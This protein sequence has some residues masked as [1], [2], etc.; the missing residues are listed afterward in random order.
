MI[1]NAKVS[2]R[3]FGTPTER[4]QEWTSKFSPI[5][6]VRPLTV[7]IGIGSIRA[8]RRQRRARLKTR[9]RTVDLVTR[10]AVWASGC[11]SGPGKSS[12]GFGPLGSVYTHGTCR[13]PGVYHTKDGSGLWG[14]NDRFAGRTLGTGAVIDT[15]DP[16]KTTVARPL[17]R[18]LP[19]RAPR[20]RSSYVAA[21]VRPARDPSERGWYRGR[22]WYIRYVAWRESETNLRKAILGGRRACGGHEGGAR[23]ESENARGGHTVS[24]IKGRRRRRRRRLALSI[25][26]P[27]ASVATAGEGGSFEIRRPPAGLVCA[28]ETRDRGK[29]R[30]DDIDRKKT[31]ETERYV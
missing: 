19:L 20:A 24:K 30:N 1:L 15:P 27:R 18:P 29:E 8:F 4:S 21:D 17:P 9:L 26:F 10:I 7:T 31:T 3:T 14:N 16:N 28:R 6:K 2:L 22:C 23:K 25:S 11:E 5:K 13:G 12:K